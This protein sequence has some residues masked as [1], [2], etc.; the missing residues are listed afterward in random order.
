MLLS[1]L[2]FHVSTVHNFAFRSSFKT[3]LELSARKLWLLEFERSGVV[4]AEN[5]GFAVACG[6]S[7]TV[8]HYDD[9]HS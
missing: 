8:M 4:V 7:W 5:K 9:G 1:C 3:V 2:M 6:P